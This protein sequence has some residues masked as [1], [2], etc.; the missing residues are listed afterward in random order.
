[1]VNGALFVELVGMVRD[2]ANVD[3]TKNP[4][5]RMAIAHIDMLGVLTFISCTDSER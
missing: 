5:Q 2:L 4:I 3:N 1:M